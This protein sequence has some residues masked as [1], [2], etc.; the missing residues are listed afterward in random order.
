MIVHEGHT[1]AVTSVAYSPDGKS[2]ASGSWDNT[3]R[4]WD[5]Q[6]PSINGEPLTGHSNWISSV[7]YSPL[8]NIIA[9]GSDDNT[10]RIWDINT[11]RQL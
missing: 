9:S 4:I 6:S 8:G 10:I 7:S 2:V 1:D 11:R 5:A 3:I